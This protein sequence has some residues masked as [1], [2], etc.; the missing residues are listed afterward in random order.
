MINRKMI[1]FKKFSQ[2][3]QSIVDFILK[4]PDCI[5]HSNAKDLAS[6]TF[7]SSPTIIRFCQK[8]GYIGYPEF[9][10]EYIQEYFENKPQV[11]TEISANSS[12]SDVL[13]LLPLRYE[14]VAKNTADRIVKMDF[15]YIVHA[16]RQAD[17]IDF[18]ATGINFG[19]AQAACVRFSNLGYHAQVQLG[20]NKH[21]ILS[22]TN[23]DRRNILSFLISHTGENEAVL[24]VAR[25]L[26]SQ[27]MRMV[28]IGRN[29]NELHRLSD[30]HILWD[31][32]RYDKSFDNLSYPISLMFI[33]DLLYLELANI[34]KYNDPNAPSLL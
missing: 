25:Y 14:W 22:N 15:A 3:E 11:L 2:S 34:N 8:L 21:Y 6:M 20:I 17:Y 7:T 23:E 24:E 27:N 32:D 5:L 28:H 12:L 10:Y 31:N 29:D 30:F 9:R 33:L 16:F 19:I 1:E 13:Q 4:N 18:Y 26:K